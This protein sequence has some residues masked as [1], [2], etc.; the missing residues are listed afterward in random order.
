M[1]RPQPAPMKFSGIVKDLIPSE[2]PP[3][4]WTDGRNV[5]FRA[6]ETQRVPG[7][8]QFANAGR[9]CDAD[10]TRHITNAGGSWWVYA[11]AT[12]AK[13]P[14]VGVTDGVSHWSIMPAG[15]VAINAK[16]ARLSIHDLNG[17]IILNHPEIGAFFWDGD[18][19]HVMTRLPNF[20]AGWF[21][22]VMRAHKN[23]L[24]ALNINDDS[25]A[26]PGRVTWSSAADPGT[27]PPE[28]LPTPTNDAGY[29]DF[30]NPSGL[31]VDGVSLRD[32]FF[33]SK[34]NWTG[35]L[36]Y[37]GGQFVFRS[38]DVFPSAGMWAQ[39]CAVELGNVVYQFTGRGM[40][41]KH[42]GTQ[43]VDLLYGIGQ[44][45]VTSR[46][47]NEYPT[48]VF[49]YRDG[50]AGQV[51][52]CYP[53]GSN[54]KCTEAISIE[55]VSGKMGIRDLPGVYM[56]ANGPTVQANQTWDADA[57]SWDSDQSSWD[58]NASPFTT[59][60]IVFAAADQGL[61]EQGAAA[62][63]WTPSGPALLPAYVTRDGID[64][65][66]ADYRKTLSLLRPRLKGSTGD[67]VQFRLSAQDSDSA[68]PISVG[69]LTYT[70]GVDDQVEFFIDGRL[71][72]I[73]MASV[74]GQPW[75][76]GKLYPFGRKAGRW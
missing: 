73:Y 39:E 6:G 66:D 15:W 8:A 23:W 27:V 50:Q 70:I 31:L 20:K 4:V 25:G 64:L 48:S 34:Q 5:I 57:A 17:I 58:E 51:L 69:P 43:V 18:P 1:S 41:I 54:Q 74:G 65:D 75:T 28:W 9:V 29:I 61:L 12:K 40:F 37:I 72:S 24:M 35:A 59:D 63:Q 49:V 13:T 38:A 76:L 47:N 46:M 53:T 56:A 36:Q 45:Y 67:Q 14:G 33:I 2:C 71:L 10:V 62:T 19:T 42:D 11:G 7:E 68:P 60:K 32:N 52:L 44:D 3:D 30:A 21:C 26:H 55:V 16:L 22:S